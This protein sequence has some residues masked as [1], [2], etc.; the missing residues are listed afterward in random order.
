V[1]IASS[2]LTLLL[3]L[4]LG[5]SPAS[6][7]LKRFRIGRSVDGRPIRVVER[8]DHSSRNDV[9]VV[10]CIHGN[11]C[12]ALRVIKRLRRTPVPDDVDLFLIKTVNPDGRKA[13]TRQNGR[14]VDLNRNFK[15]KW[16]AI[17]EPWDTYYS[18]P[19]PWSEPET[20]AVRH[21]VLD[22]K[23]RVTIWYHQ[24]MALVTKLGGP[25]DRRIQRRYARRVG[26][27]LR[28]L[29]RPGTATRWQNHKLKRTTAFV[30]ELHGGG[31]SRSAV[32]THTRA[33]KEVARMTRSNRTS[34]M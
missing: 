31:M 9:V 26:L 29:E 16:K 30:V 27:P 28:H 7:E 13:G 10:G 2:T 4:G 12:A 6:A 23:P 20:R 3:A 5:A 33:V 21:F 24:A 34:R 19:H 8:G 15:H 22:V 25:R 17:G 32:R 1:R 14:G 11:E 18:G